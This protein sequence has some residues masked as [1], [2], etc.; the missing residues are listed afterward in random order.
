MKIQEFEDV[1]NWWKH[2]K[3]W[4]ENSIL[5]SFQIWD[6]LI[7]FTIRD[8]KSLLDNKSTS[9]NMDLRNKNTL[10]DIFKK[11]NNGEKVLKCFQNIGLSLYR[12]KNLRWT[13]LSLLPKNRNDERTVQNRLNWS[14]LIKSNKF[15]F[16]VLWKVSQL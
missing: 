1:K 3:F 4:L 15:D 10:N 11:F 8:L 14:K 7:V 5:F 16:K 2:K 12:R 9:T 13:H 6:K